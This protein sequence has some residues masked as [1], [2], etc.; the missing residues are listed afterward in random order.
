MFLKNKLGETPIHTAI[1]TPEKNI[2]IIIMLANQGSELKKLR[3]TME[4][5]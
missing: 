5:P 2:K 1:M 3:I 4:I